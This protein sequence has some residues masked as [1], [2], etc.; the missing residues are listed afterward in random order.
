[1]PKVCINLRVQEFE[2]LAAFCKVTPYTK[3]D[4][5]LEAIN[6]QFDHLE[7][8]NICLTYMKSKRRTASITISDD[9]M[10]NLDQL[11][12]F[13]NVTPAQAGLISVRNFVAYG[14]EGHHEFFNCV[15]KQ[16]IGT[17]FMVAI[18]HD[19]NEAVSAHKFSASRLIRE[20][21]R[22][23][24]DVENLPL[25]PGRVE[26]VK[27][28]TIRAYLPDESDREI[29]LSLMSKFKENRGRVIARCLALVHLYQYQGVG[30]SDLE[31]F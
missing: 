18:P 23:C 5:I 31:L 20:A 3:R 14:E 10:D 27:S 15:P 26:G 7:D 13:M 11:A 9:D 17:S 28:P 21:L 22:T 29:L 8:E 19:V 4:V 30:G 2:K 1:M 12:E 25:I 16:E 24:K 6:W